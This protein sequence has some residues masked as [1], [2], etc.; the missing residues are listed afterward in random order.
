MSDFSDTA[1]RE[2]GKRKDAHRLGEFA[3]IQGVYGGN[4]QLVQRY[5]EYVETRYGPIK[6]GWDQGLIFGAA[7]GALTFMAEQGWFPQQLGLL[8]KAVEQL[9]VDVGLAS[10]AAFALSYGV[11]KTIDTVRIFHKRAE[12]RNQLDAGITSNLPSAVGIPEVAEPARPELSL[13]KG[14]VPIPA[15]LAAVPTGVN[16]PIEL[17]RINPRV[18]SVFAAQRRPDQS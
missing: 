10:G 18:R 9:P 11:K 7:T 16:R 6:D 3:A 13:P 17:S 5:R 15:A 8:T 4:K 2:M 12:L 14:V 1:H